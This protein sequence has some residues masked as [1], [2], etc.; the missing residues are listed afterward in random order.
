MLELDARLVCTVTVALPLSIAWGVG[1]LDQFDS[2]ELHFWQRRF[3]F[4]GPMFCRLVGYPAG[5]I[6]GEVRRKI[7]RDRKTIGL[8]RREEI[9]QLFTYTD[10]KSVV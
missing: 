1:R 7:A 10:R 6:E 3:S 5:R 9:E 8:R 2:R 4:C